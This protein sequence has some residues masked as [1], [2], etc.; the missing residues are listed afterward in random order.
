MSLKE[1]VADIRRRYGVSIS[2][3][4]LRSYYLQ[5]KIKY[6]TVDLHVVRKRGM[7]DLLGKQ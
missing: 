5:R 6:R 7:K 2:P 1:R 3:S 4:V